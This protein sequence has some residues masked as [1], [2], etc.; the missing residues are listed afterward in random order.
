MSD[1]KEDIGSGGGSD[2]RW[3]QWDVQWAAQTLSVSN[4]MHYAYGLVRQVESNAAPSSIPFMYNGTEFNCWLRKC[5]MHIAS[6]AE[7]V[8]SQWR[9]LAPPDR[10]A[11]AQAACGLTRFALHCLVPKLTSTNNKKNKKPQRAGG[12]SGSAGGGSGNAHL[13]ELTSPP[14]PLLWNPEYVRVLQTLLRMKTQLL[15]VRRNM[16]NAAATNAVD[17]KKRVE[18][19]WQV[20]R[21]ETFL[22]DYMRQREAV[23]RQ[24]PKAKHVSTTEAD[25]FRSAFVSL[26]APAYRVLGDT[27][28]KSVLQFREMIYAYEN[29][30]DAHTQAVKLHAERSRRRGKRSASAAAAPL[31]SFDKQLHRFASFWDRATLDHRETQTRRDKQVDRGIHL[32]RIDVVGAE[33]SLT[34]PPDADLVSS[35]AI[36]AEATCIPSSATTTTKQ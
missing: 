25:D 31:S 21:A 16:T 8:L 7:D 1:K 2:G 27:F 22:L 10:L 17:E 5:F 33:V 19:A 32:L 6:Y 15:F 14:Q 23:E 26:L 3:A 35:L 30:L 12:G 20:V 13:F 18:V 9:T 36:R 4:A 24:Y 11:H 34:I 28:A 29:S